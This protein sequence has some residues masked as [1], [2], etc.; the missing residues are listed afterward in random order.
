MD[1]PVPAAAPLPES[2]S[3]REPELRT[4]ANDPDAR[5]SE[6]LRFF[7]AATEIEKARMRPA[8]ANYELLSTQ[9]AAA[10]PNQGR[11]YPNEK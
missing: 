4:V 10:I 9:P 5:S 6:I 3:T 8:A 2:A 11:K 1:G 7:V